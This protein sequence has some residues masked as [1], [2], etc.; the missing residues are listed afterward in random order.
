[1]DIEH[2]NNNV[3]IMYLVTK[4]AATTKNG[5]KWVPIWRHNP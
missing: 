5:K 1:M 3:A 2:P 4:N